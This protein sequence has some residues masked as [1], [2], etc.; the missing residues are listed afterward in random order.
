MTKER[1]VVLNKNL[2]TIGKD[3]LC[4]RLYKR[5]VFSKNKEHALLGIV[6]F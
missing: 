3:L 6:F 4:L 2:F 5:G 1:Y